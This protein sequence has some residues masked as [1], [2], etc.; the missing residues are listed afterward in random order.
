M[1]LPPARYSFGG[2]EHIFVEL[3]KQGITVILVTH[4]TDIAAYA[5]RKIVFK[6]GRIVE[7]TARARIGVLGGGAK[8]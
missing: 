6:D 3:N 5:R 1:S 7:D 8:L 4:E 2:D